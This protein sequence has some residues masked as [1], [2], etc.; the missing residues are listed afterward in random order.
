MVCAN[1]R[2]EILFAGWPT[3]PSLPVSGSAV[4]A[5]G[6]AARTAWR[7]GEAHVDNI[8]VYGAPVSVRVERVTG[9]MKVHTA[10]YCVG[11]TALGR[12]TPMAA[13]SSMWCSMAARSRPAQPAMTSSSMA[14]GSVSSCSCAV[15]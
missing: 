5:L 14:T 8:Q 15:T 9:E 7:D 10:G 12:G 2:Y 11:G 13:S 4:E 3:P 6:I 1:A